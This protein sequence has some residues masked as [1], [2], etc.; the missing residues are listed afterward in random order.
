MSNGLMLNQYVGYYL[1]GNKHF[2]NFRGGIE[3][4]EAFTK[5]RRSFNYDVAT[6]DKTQRFDMMITLKISWNL[7][8]F[9]KPPR[10]FYY[11]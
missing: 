8:I 6:V 10:R 2:V 5:S 1:F 11:N 4:Q 7:P 3:L 9:E